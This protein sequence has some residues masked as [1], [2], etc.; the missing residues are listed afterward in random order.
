MIPIEG[1]EFERLVV[2]ATCFGNNWQ[3]QSLELRSN[4]RLASRIVEQRLAFTAGRHSNF[5]DTD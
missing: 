4:G 1:E 2:I 5:R 3:T